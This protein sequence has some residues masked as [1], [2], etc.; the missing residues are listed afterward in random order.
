MCEQG[1]RLFSMDPHHI[2]SLTLGEEVESNEQ[3][4]LLPSDNEIQSHEDDTSDATDETEFEE[5][6]VLGKRIYL[7]F[8]FETTIRYLC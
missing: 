5:D 6:S 7:I 1:Y 3:D 8:Q 4:S 2:D